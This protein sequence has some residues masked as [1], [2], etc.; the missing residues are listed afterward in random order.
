MTENNV[1]KIDRSDYVPNFKK[2]DSDDHIDLGYIEGY[3]S[4]GSPFRSER[5]AAF[6]MTFLTIFIPTD[7]IENTS[8]EEIKRL[9]IKEELIIFNDDKYSEN[10]HEGNNVSMKKITDT[11]SNNFWEIQILVGDEDKVYIETG[12][13]YEHQKI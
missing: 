2:R 8:P 9:L 7:G 4:N 10:V 6:Q 11:N 12:R 1:S 13:N 5:W 3:L